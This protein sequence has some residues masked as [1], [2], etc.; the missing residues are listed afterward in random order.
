MVATP[1]ACL[2]LRAEH[3]GNILIA[4]NA[5]D[6]AMWTVALLRNPEFCRHLGLAG[7]TTS[8]DEYEWDIFGQQVVALYEEM[9]AP[10]DPGASSKG[11]TS[12][13]AK[14]SETQLDGADPGL[15]R[16]ESNV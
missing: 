8:R 16:K 3:G 4:D 13:V 12:I 11:T 7:R 6:F 9:L 1:L 15:L 10:E 14:D 5:Q 2:G